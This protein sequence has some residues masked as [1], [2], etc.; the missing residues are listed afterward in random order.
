MPQDGTPP[1]GD[2]P[3]A[4]EER[5]QQGFAER[6]GSKVG[7][8][9]QQAKAVCARANALSFEQLRAL[10]KQGDA[11][12]IKVMRAMRSGGQS[13]RSWKDAAQVYNQIPPE[14][15]TS[16]GGAADF[17]TGK[18][19]SHIQ[20]RSSFGKDG[21]LA[22]KR[23]SG[24]ADNV[25]IENVQ[26]NAARA[27]APMSLSEQVGIRLTN[28][29]PV[30]KGA[31]RD[32]ALIGGIISA[33]VNTYEV[34]KDQKSVKEAVKHVA[35]D[36]ATAGVTSGLIA[37]VGMVCPPVGAVLGPT[38]LAKS[39]LWDT[40]AV[41]W[42][43]DGVASTYGWLAGKDQGASQEERKGGAD[44]GM[45]AFPPWAWLVV[46]DSGVVM[47]VVAP[48]LP[49]GPPTCDGP[50]VSSSGERGENE[51]SSK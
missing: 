51:E 32:G 19:I 12:A 24:R 27:N 15:R 44:P 1:A 7:V 23:S 29:L 20:P 31:V 2:G 4:A 49:A 10:A 38:L 34:C 8:V 43:A 37:A 39:L 18:S 13:T 33:G 14:L 30:I 25:V 16:A 9:G 6:L 36:T 22:S 35:V 5:P 45:P 17:R 21:N 50:A 40:G 47:A 42:A 46:D 11:D 41:H 28:G 48:V 3:A 26:T